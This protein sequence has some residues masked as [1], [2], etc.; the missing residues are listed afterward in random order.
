MFK[1]HRSGKQVIG[2]WKNDF[3]VLDGVKHPTI[4][5][6]VPLAVGKYEGR[7]KSEAK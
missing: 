2:R 1:Y 5:D 3:L 7:S 6:L 4:E